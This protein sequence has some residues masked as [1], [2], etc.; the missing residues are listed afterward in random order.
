[1]PEEEQLP[2]RFRSPTPHTA[3]PPADRVPASAR[4]TMGGVLPNKMYQRGEMMLA[5]AEA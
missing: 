5:K 2:R 4:M 1:M 3:R